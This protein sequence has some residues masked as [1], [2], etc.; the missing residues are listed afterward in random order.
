MVRAGLLL[1]DDDRLVLATVA[2]GLE[3]AGYDVQT[4][5]GGK[6]A[7]ELLAQHPFDLVILDVRMP[8]VSGVAVSDVLKARGIP[9]IVLSAY[10]DEDDLL[11]IIDNG[12]FGYLAKP[13]DVR[14]MVPAIEA[15][16]GRASDMARS[17]ASESQL[18]SALERDQNTSKVIGILMERHKLSSDSAYDLLRGYARSQRRKVVDVAAELVVAESALN[19]LAPPKK[20]ETAA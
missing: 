2:S 16:L 14:N 15:A 20:P 11:K 18:K 12:A 13:I 5:P 19:S 9:Y 4:A 17:R 6:E 8:D 3:S 1:V 10:T 7:L